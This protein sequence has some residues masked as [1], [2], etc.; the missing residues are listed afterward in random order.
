MRCLACRLAAPPASSQVDATRRA[1]ASAVWLGSPG[2][3]SVTTGGAGRGGGRGRRAVTGP[4]AMSMGLEV[5]TALVAGAVAACGG[6]E[7]RLHPIPTKNGVTNESTR[8][9]SA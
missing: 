8:A 9:D 1:S 5:A 2:M 4:V 3:G 6:A 7:E